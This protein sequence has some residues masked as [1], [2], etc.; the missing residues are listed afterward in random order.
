MT[1]RLEVVAALAQRRAVIYLRVSTKEQLLRDGDPEGYSIPAQREAC[2]RKAAALGAEVVETY[3]DRGESARSADRAD[4]QRMLAEIGKSPV[5]YV[6][7]HK[8]DRL[9][10]NRMDDATIT[11]AIQLSGAQLVSVT[12]NIDETPSGTLLHGIMSSIA[13]FYSRN[14]ANEV[15]KGL[16]QKIRAGG[17]SGRAPI[18]Y[19]NVRRMVEGHEVRTVD[20]DPERAPLIAF[21]YETYA[22]GTWSLSELADELNRRGLASRP[23]KGKPSTPMTPTKLHSIL[24]NRYYLGVVQWKGVEYPG[25]HPALISPELFSEVQNLLEQRRTAGERTQR[26]EHYLAGTLRCGRCDSRL[27]FGYGRSKTGDQHAYFFCSQRHSRA[28]SCDLPYIPADLI[29][30]E[31]DGIWAGERI[32]AEVARELETRLAADL[33]AQ[34]AQTVKEAAD[35]SKRIEKLKRERYRWAEMAMEGG[36]PAD[37]A[38]EKQGQLAQQLDSCEAAL[39]RV[40]RVQHGAMVTL[41]G[42][43]RLL[44]HCHEA[45]VKHSESGRRL[46]N[47]A[48]FHG[49]DVDTDGR[50]LRVTVRRD[51]LFESLRLAASQL[52]EIS[53]A[54]KEAPGTNP[55]ASSSSSERVESSNYSVVVELRRLELL[56]LTLPA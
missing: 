17:T 16:E 51:P 40:A 46:M 3:V 10:R 22:T 15:V 52:P 2:L 37:I 33:Q 23:T 55:D 50:G 25:R 30:R 21:A 38:K 26:H 47:Q 36:V 39:G 42:A 5:D 56:T 54:K 24:R 13:E 34:N 48:C 4:L 19:L 53:S 29:E 32:E 8:V 35:L 44:E 41:T 9:A 28:K 18:G 14:L 1:P 20:F 27:L 11:A 43:L 7:V 6:I 31:V 12:E 49:I 45:Y